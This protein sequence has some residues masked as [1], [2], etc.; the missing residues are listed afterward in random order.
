MITHGT[1]TIA[2]LINNRKLFELMAY[3]DYWKLGSERCWEEKKQH[4]NAQQHTNRMRRNRLLCVSHRP[5]L[6]R[7]CTHHSIATYAYNKFGLLGPLSDGW[8]LPMTTKI[9]FDFNNGKNMC[10]FCILFG[11]IWLSGKPSAKSHFEA[12]H[13]QNHQMRIFIILYVFFSLQNK[14]LPLG[15]YWY[16]DR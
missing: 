15:W 14:Y 8:T 4:S 12:R 5:N 9:I 13:H 7:V 16:Q 11:S 6:T 3:Y 10:F 2:I 1:H